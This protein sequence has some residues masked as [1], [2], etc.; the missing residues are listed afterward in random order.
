MAFDDAVKFVLS[1]EGGYVCDPHD[2]G[3]ETCFG[4]SKRA[5]PELDIKHLTLPQAKD[6][7]RKD[8]WEK[9]GLGL[10][11][12]RLALVLFDTSVNAGRSQAVKILQ[13]SLN[14]SAFPRLIEDGILGSKTLTAAM[15]QCDLM[16]G[17]KTLV[18]DYLLQRLSLYRTLLERYHNKARFFS[19]WVN[20][21]LDLYHTIA[22]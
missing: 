15:Q 18:R 20:R 17:E 3:G 1:H 9:L 14:L 6:I 12:D 10:F 19:G 13:R 22:G 7:Y 2:S 11:P 5:Y 8:Y 16:N 21:T 4:I